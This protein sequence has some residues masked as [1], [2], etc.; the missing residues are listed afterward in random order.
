MALYQFIKSAGLPSGVYFYQM[1]RY[2]F[3]SKKSGMDETVLTPLLRNS[4]RTQDGYLGI[5][6]LQGLARFDGTRF[7]TFEPVSFCRAR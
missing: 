6:K 4:A 3:I 1:R 5:G 2:L 7:T